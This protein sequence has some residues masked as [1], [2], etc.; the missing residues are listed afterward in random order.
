MKEIWTGDESAGKSY[1]AAKRMREIVYRN[2]R[3][4]K[5]TGVYRPLWINSS[6][7][8]SE[9]FLELAYDRNVPIG[10][11]DELEELVDKQ[12]CDV[13]IDEIGRYLDS[14]LWALLPFSARSWFAQAA[15]MG[16]EMYG[17]AQN[18]PQVDANFRRLVNR[19]WYVEKK[20]GSSRP[21]ETKPPVKAVWGLILQWKL[22][23]K[24]SSDELV[25]AGRFPTPHWLQKDVT[26]LFDTQATVNLSYQSYS[27]HFERK[28]RVCGKVEILHK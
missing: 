20:F 16:V 11:W 1:L 26:E 8:P 3:W 7:K 9:K 13:F 15:K 23:P 10:Q 12:G 4:F 17:T 2:G 24:K 5:R 28:C 25:Y 22:D 18:F 14:R 19:L 6:L 27:D 21:H